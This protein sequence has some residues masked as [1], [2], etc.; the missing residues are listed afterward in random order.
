MIITV[1]PYLKYIRLISKGKIETF[2][3]VWH[4]YHIPE[5]NMIIVKHGGSYGNWTVSYRSLD[6]IYQLTWRKEEP[7]KPI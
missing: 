1:Q 5:H 3:P 6:E 7:C 2:Q 4:C